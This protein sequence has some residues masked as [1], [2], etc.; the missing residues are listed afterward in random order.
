MD[1][2]S[3]TETQYNVKSDPMA[4]GVSPSGPASCNPLEVTGYSCTFLSSP[5]PPAATST[6]L[7]AT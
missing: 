3:I 5:A 2:P 7:E 1:N 4:G 6:C